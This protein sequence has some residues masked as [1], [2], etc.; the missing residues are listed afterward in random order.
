MLARF[1]RSMGVAYLYFPHLWLI[2]RV[3]PR[4]AT[5]LNRPLVWA[6]WLAT[7]LGAHRRT[8]ANIKALHT[9]LTC[10]ATVNTVLRRYLIIKS[11]NF[12]EWFCYTTPRGRKYLR[13]TYT[14]IEGR[15]HLD[16]ALAEQRGVILLTFHFG[17]VRT[18]FA[19]LAALG[20]DICEH[21]ARRTTYAGKTY[22]SIAVAAREKVAEVDNQSEFRHIYHRPLQSFAVM[23]RQLRKGGIVAVNGDG[24]TGDQFVT[25]PFLGGTIGLPAGPAQL[26]ARSGAVV[27]PIFTLYEGLFRHRIVIHP[28]MDV[29]GNSQEDIEQATVEYSRLLEGYVRR[30]PWAWWTWRRLRR[31]QTSG[32]ALQLKIETL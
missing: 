13:D 21:V 20:Y 16:A 6:M 2:R 10:D 12:I 22:D 3:G 27:I 17:M 30:Y 11:Q 7:F 23:F 8:R 28:G 18:A 25:T 32:D 24:M 1:A 19:M 14:Q 9:Q 29:P 5:L 15:E 31:E 26:A 4:I